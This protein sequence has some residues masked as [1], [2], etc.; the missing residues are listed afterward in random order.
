MQA[1]SPA[2]LVLTDEERD[3][4]LELLDRERTTLPVEIRHTRTGKFRDMLKHRLSVV[5]ELLAR[6]RED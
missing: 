6:L 3:I 2:P 1:I 4:V 5:T